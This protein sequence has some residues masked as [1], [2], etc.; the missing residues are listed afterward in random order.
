MGA[1][2]A[3]RHE[4]AGA[5]IDIRGKL[6]T[7]AHRGRGPRRESGGRGGADGSADRRRQEITGENPDHDRQEVPGRPA[8]S[9]ENTREQAKEGREQRAEEGRGDL[10]ATRLRLFVRRLFRRR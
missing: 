5:P 9:S 8:V 10:L 3:G 7:S 2:P 1:Q 6:G 4:V